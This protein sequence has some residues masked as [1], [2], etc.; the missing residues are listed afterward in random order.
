MFVRMFM[1]YIYIWMCILMFIR[2]NYDIC[3]DVYMDPKGH[4]RV[5]VPS[6]LIRVVL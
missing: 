3:L 1:I 2:I 4:L 5:P 6:T